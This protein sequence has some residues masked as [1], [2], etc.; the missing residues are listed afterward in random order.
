MKRYLVT[1]GAGFIGSNFVR[2]LSREEPGARVV[3]L[4]N[5]S[6][7]GHRGNLAGLDCHFVH[8]DIRDSSLVESLMS[9]CDI[10]LNFAA[11]THV[12]RSILDASEFAT[13]N[14]QGTLTL[15][16]AACRWKLSLF[17]QIGTDEVYGS[18]KEGACDEE[19]L[20]RPGNPY[21]A[22]KAAA[23]HLTL[24]FANT[25]ELPV[26]VTRC[27]NNYGPRQFPEKLI[28]FF[29]TRAV[30]GQRLPLYGDGLNRRDW[31]HV[32]DHARALLH[33]TRHGR[34]GEVYN[35]SCQNELTNLE[36]V[37]ALL[38]ILEKP[39][40][41]IE[42]VRDRPGHDRRYA[43]DPGKLRSTGWLPAHGDFEEGLRQTVDWYLKNQLWWRE[44]QASHEFTSFLER[45]YTP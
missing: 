34:R 44:V 35:I 18:V 42:P 24:A 17:V 9:E 16:Q 28:P 8:G 38:A 37:Q 27:G 7:S 36:V 23:D 45:S 40:S 20:L 33:L 6:Y 31:I 10:C 12:D 26:L 1:G 43:L 39:E 15:L 41:L 3:V 21:A 11:Q 5:L 13:T 32:Q 19:C 22:T 2:L 30:Q 25:H 4:D 29:I 14:V